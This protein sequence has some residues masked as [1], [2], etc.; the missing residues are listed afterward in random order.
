[1]LRLYRVGDKE[2]AWNTGGIMLTGE[3]Q[4]NSG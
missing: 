2:L 1:M 3:S 4:G